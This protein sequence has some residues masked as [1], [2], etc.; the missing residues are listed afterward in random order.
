VA[1][2]FDTDAVSE[3]LKRAPS[4]RYVEWLRSTPREEH[5]TSAVVMGELYRGAFRSPARERHLRNIDERI[6][7]AII[8][9]PYDAEVAR[10]FG[11]IYAHLEST[12]NLLADADLQIAA[13]A[14][15]HGLDLVTDNLRH[16][17]RVPGLTIQPILADARR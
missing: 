5:F 13:T 4:P 12:G 9:L 3:V 7:P 6:V 11:E 2:L 14:L 16:F 17:A 15:Y 8:I 10:V 1:Y